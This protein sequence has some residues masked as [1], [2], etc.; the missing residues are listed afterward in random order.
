M[1]PRKKVLLSLGA[2]VAVTLGLCG[3]VYS[4]YANL[5]K[6]Q[7]D[8]ERLSAEID[9]NRTMLAKSPDLEREVILQRETDEVVRTILP[10]S[11]DM[12]NFTRSLHSFAQEAKVRIN[13]LQEKNATRSAKAAKTDFEKAAYTVQFE[14]DA[15]QILSF[16]N[17]VESS[18]RFMSVP[19]FQLSAAKKRRMSSEGGPQL[20]AVTL[21]VETYV[22]DE[23]GT[24]QRVQVDGYERKREALLPDIAKRTSDL[25]LPKFAYK[26]ARN[27]RDPWIDPRVMATDVGELVPIPEQLAYVD[28]LAE[29]TR[30]AVVSWEEYDMAETLVAQIKVRSE[31]E[32]HLAAIESEIRR[33]EQES[34]LTY[35]P[36][37][38]R[39]LVE[40][41]DEVAL[42]RHRLAETEQKT[43]SIAHLEQTIQ[44]MEGH[45]SLDEFVLALQVFEAIKP[46][47]EAVLPGE[48]RIDELVERIR[49]YERIARTA[50]KFN[51]MDLTIGGV[52]GGEGHYIALINK[53]SYAVKEMVGPDLQV[54]EIT[55]EYVEFL[56]EGVVL[57]KAIGN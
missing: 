20:H 9:T 55:P 31:L 56:F 45:L 57:R 4:Q 12:P 18:P 26:G 21:E 2:G 49:F 37:R 30:V 40:V 42:I 54:L 24:P 3:L 35:E 34:F 44:S 16:F 25:V 6:L 39:Y 29:R 23:K 51:Q 17:L 41:V 5:E 8:A 36:A 53:R 48:A 22:Y 19:S 43:P 15:F 47:L 28:V 46:R 32:G 11:K 14:G 7:G 13:S 10:N 27:R 50:I 33:V 52:G 38:R 1:E